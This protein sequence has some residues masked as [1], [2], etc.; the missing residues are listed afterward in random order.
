[1]LIGE[2]Q[3]PTLHKWELLAAMQALSIYIIIRLDEGE[4]DHNNFDSLLVK[5]FIVST[6]RNSGSND[7]KLMDLNNTT[8]NSP[9]T[10]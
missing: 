10:R 4:T 6:N 2:S 5:T 8:G 3:H 7:L 1:M 9:T